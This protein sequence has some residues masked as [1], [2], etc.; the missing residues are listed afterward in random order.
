MQPR[1]KL[2]VAV[3]SSLLSSGFIPAQ[4]ANP[5]QLTRPAGP[6]ADGQIGITPNNSQLTPAEEKSASATCPWV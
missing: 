5:D 4:A 3:I 1:I 2:I 6:S